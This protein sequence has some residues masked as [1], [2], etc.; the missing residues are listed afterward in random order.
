[1]GGFHPRI[2]AEDTD[3]TYRLY[4]RGWRV[5]YA[6]RAECYEE[7]PE[8]WDVRFKQLRRWSRG[9]NAA[10]IRHFI[11]LMRSRYINTIQKIDGLM[12]LGCYAIPPLLVLAWLANLI[13]ILAAAVPLVESFAISLFVVA[14][15][16]FGNFAPVFEVGA[17]ELLDGTG[18]RL[19]LL[20]LMFVLFLFN[21]WAISMGA[22]DALGD[23]VRGR[24]P[25]WDKTLR[26]T[27]APRAS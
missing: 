27:S 4:A 8:T 18:D 11:P 17:A 19:R 25:T 14:Y 5:A 21:S 1:M 2:L 20:P 16:A 13:L 6:N 9:H 7:V 15:G 22:L 10:M 3:L 12:L 24:M 23:A 26:F